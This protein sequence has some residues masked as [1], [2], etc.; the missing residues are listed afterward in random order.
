MTPQQIVEDRLQELSDETD[1]RVLHVAREVSKELIQRNILNFGIFPDDEG[2]LEIQGSTE[3]HSF[4]V[5]ITKSAYILTRIFNGLRM[6]GNNCQ[7]YA[8]IAQWIK[9]VEIPKDRQ[10]QT[11][12]RTAQQIQDEIKR[13]E[14]EYEIQKA[15]EE[16]G[17]IYREPETKDL[18]IS[19]PHTEG[20]HSVQIM[21][22]IRDWFSVD[23]TMRGES[24][25]Y[26]TTDFEYV[27]SFQQVFVEREIK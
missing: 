17:A 4:L 14:K 24:A 5:E 18:W 13:L 9:H 8:E 6:Q 20:T 23:I 25:G 10:G 1:S 26:R 3:K 11:M 22:R 2:G 27:G 16:A 19:F 15:K 7:N 12:T 21:Y